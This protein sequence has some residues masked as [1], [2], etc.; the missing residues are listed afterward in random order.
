MSRLGDSLYDPPGFGNM[1][2]KSRRPRE[3]TET[4][5]ARRQ[6][7][8]S[9]PGDAVIDDLRPSGR[10]GMFWRVSVASAS[11]GIERLSV[12]RLTRDTV[13]ALRLESGS[14]WTPA[15]ASAVLEAAHRSEAR[16]YALNALSVRSMSSGRLRTKINARGAPKEI[17]TAVVEELERSGLVDDRAMAEQIGRSALAQNPVGARVLEARLRRRDIP[18][19]VAREVA[20]DLTADRDAEADAERVARKKLRSVRQNIE[21]EVVERRLV[22]A[23]AR[24]GFAPS[25]CRGVA[26]RLIVERDDGQADPG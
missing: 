25:V 6:M 18:P 2:G 3:A 17:A 19:S 14:R 1:G 5:L 11:L 20:A 13:D 16:R 7:Y 10:Q 9:P 22:A 24:R 12:A 26:R 15:T 8:E 21:R 4:D 23:L